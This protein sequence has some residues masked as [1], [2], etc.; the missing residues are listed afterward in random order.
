MSCQSAGWWESRWMIRWWP[1]GWGEQGGRY[2][3]VQGQGTDL[4]NTVV[5]ASLATGGQLHVLDAGMVTDPQAVAGYLASRGIDYLKAVPSHLAALGA[6]PDGMAGVLP[7]RS[8]VLGGEAS[9][10][11][12]VREL[13]AAAGQRGVF[14]HYG[15]KEATI[16]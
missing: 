11:G 14:N 8:L 3:L 12:W 10:A 15:P 6:G 4:G 1:G 13:T 2:A 5:L 7:G 16:G 9:A